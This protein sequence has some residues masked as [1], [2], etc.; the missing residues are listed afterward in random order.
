LAEALLREYTLKI[1]PNFQRHIFHEWA[2]KEAQISYTGKEH[3]VSSE[4]KGLSRGCLNRFFRQMEFPH[5]ISLHRRPIHG[6]PSQRDDGG[7]SSPALDDTSFL[8]GGDAALIFGSEIGDKVPIR[9]FSCVSLLPEE[10]GPR[11]NVILPDDIPP[12]FESYAEVPPFHER[13]FQGI[14]QDRISLDGWEVSLTN[15]VIPSKANGDSVDDKWMYCVSLVF[16]KC[17]MARPQ[18]NERDIDEQCFNSKLQEQK[19]SKQASQGVIGIALISRRNVTHA[20]RETLS[21]LYGDFCSVKGGGHEDEISRNHVC[22]PLVDILGVFTHSQGVEASSLSWMQL[23]QALPPVPLALA[24]ITIL[25]EQKVLFVSSRRGMLTAASFGML[26][27]LR[28]LTW[29]HLQVPLV[30]V[31]MMNELIHY[32]APFMLGFPTDEKDSVA[33][34]S[35]LP[36]DVTLVDLDVGRVILASKFANDKKVQ[37]GSDEVAAGALRSQ[38]L[39][40]A[41]TVGGQFGAAIYRNS[42]C[43]DSPFQ[44][45]PNNRCMKGDGSFSEV[46][47]ICGELISELLSGLHSCCLWVEEKQSHDEASKSCNESAIIF[48][49]DRFYSIK[50]LRAEGRYMPLIPK[51]TRTFSLGLHHFDL[52]F[53]AFLRTQCLSTYICDAKKE[54]MLFWN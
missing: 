37:G 48:D 25:L 42:W 45:I 9:R 3:L 23:L 11:E 47:N 49:E 26:Q 54:S 50:H 5:G 13:P 20:M 41:E 17:S 7:T 12:I 21:L 43:S 29:A 31:S 51:E 38:V 27:L 14:L 18:I 10:Y 16:R 2:C 44:S 46:L 19:W 15:F 22:Q 24:F 8:H 34:L 35:S 40:L 28:P 4:F 36:T 53:E 52:I 1:Y 6:T 32:P 30:P 39:F 33:V